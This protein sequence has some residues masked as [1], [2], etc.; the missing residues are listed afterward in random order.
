MAQQVDT[1]DPFFT[2]LTDA[3]RAGPGSPEWR[4]AVAHLKVNGEQVDEHRLL[5]EAREA[6]ESGK[7][8][9]SVRAGPGFTR[10]L[11]TNLEGE[12]Q[13]EGRQTKIPTATI[14]A[15]V[16]GLVIVVALAAVIYELY[17]RGHRA[18]SENNR[19]I[20]ELTQTYFSA[21]TIASNFDGS[22]PAGW[23]TIGPLPLDATGGLHPAPADVAE[24]SYQGGGLVTVEKLAADPPFAFEADLRVANPVENVIT[25]VFVSNSDQFS[26]D[27]ATAAHELVWSLRGRRQDAV[28]NGNVESQ[29][30]LPRHPPQTM[31]VRL[32]VGPQYA[33]IESG[34]KRLWAGPHQLGEGPRYVGVR[35]I[36]TG[37]KATDA[38][39]GIFVR[40]VRVQKASGPAS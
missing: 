11:L 26:A 3:L 1:T 39:D 24:G 38:T 13:R 9:R 28:A 34:G 31:S 6:L 17:P 8:Y 7:G 15:L 29:S 16:S 23:R 30:Q 32:L 20:Q 33:I 4:D 2:L 35:F 21:E 27:R 19:E 25:Q 5:I 10:K 37:G 36:R 12:K 22:I 14:V 40:S 18:S